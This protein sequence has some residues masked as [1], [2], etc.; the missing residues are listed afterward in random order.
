MRQRIREIEG[1]REDNNNDAAVCVTGRRP[2]LRERRCKGGGDN[3]CFAASPFP[4]N[5]LFFHFLKPDC[6]RAVQH[7]MLIFLSVSK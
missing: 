5:I 4:L 7:K 1:W 6:R 3:F 2:R